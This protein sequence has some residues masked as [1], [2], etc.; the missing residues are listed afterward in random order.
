MSNKTT[1][2]NI[3]TALGGGSGYDVYIGRG[4]GYGNPFVVGVDGTRKECVEKHFEWLL[5]WILYKEEIVIGV[6][7]N[8]W[9][10]EHLKELKGQRIAC[11]CKPELCHGD[12]LVWL[13]EHRMEPNF[14]VECYEVERHMKGLLVAIK[15]K[16]S[17]NSKVSEDRPT[18]SDGEFAQADNGLS[19]NRVFVSMSKTINLDN[20][21]SIRLEFG[22]GR[23]VNDGQNF[24]EVSKVCRKDAAS[25]LHDMVT[26]VKK[27][28]QNKG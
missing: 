16:K 4:F 27:Q 23:T 5:Y 14:G 25:S 26:M 19:G 1:C 2:V 24:E 18:V 20:Y 28:L 7:S 9:V 15:K 10:C 22:F 3:R 12:T 8:K 17:S 13:A 11:F 6:L 21:E